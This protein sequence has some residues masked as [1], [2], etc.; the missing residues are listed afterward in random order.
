MN[1]DDRIIELVQSDSD[2]EDWEIAERVVNNYDNLLDLQEDVK[3]VVSSRVCI[4]RRTKVRA[5]EHKIFDLPITANP[6]SDDSNL[7]VANDRVL[8]F[9]PTQVGASPE[10]KSTFDDYYFITAMGERVRWVDATIA[11]H[12]KRIG[13]L[14][15]K[16]SGIKQTMGRHQKAIDLIQE[17][18]VKC[19]GD[20]DNWHEMLG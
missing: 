4:L 6:I 19:L 14:G 9:V 8:G 3:S 13:F 16:A 20:I 17:H 12:E 10:E 18:E 2:L 5:L 1:L 7:T 11:D 15:A